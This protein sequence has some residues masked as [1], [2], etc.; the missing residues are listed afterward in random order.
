MARSGLHRLPDHL[1]EVVLATISRFRKE[2]R[3]AFRKPPHFIVITVMSVIGVTSAIP[4]R[5]LR[6]GE[7]MVFW[8]RH[9]SVTLI[10]MEKKA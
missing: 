8:E 6:D 1:Y 10:V 7:L 2:C 4:M 9:A 3:R 5:F